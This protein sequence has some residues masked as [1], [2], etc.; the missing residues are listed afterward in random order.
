MSFPA[1]VRAPFALLRV[2]FLSQ[3]PVHYRLLSIPTQ[4][5]TEAIRYAEAALCQ[6]YTDAIAVEATQRLYLSNQ[7]VSWWKPA[8]P[9]LLVRPRAHFGVRWPH[10]PLP[11]AVSHLQ[12][13]G[14]QGCIRLFYEGLPATDF[15]TLEFGQEHWYTA[16]TFP[17]ESLRLLYKSLLQ[18]HPAMR[19]ER[20]KVGAE[21]Q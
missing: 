17:L 2:P 18:H 19:F 13:D 14:L 21:V 16:G 15:D 9:F 4:V 20:W 3:Q 1:T 12:Y 11:S 8:E 10:E 5:D 7:P 6:R